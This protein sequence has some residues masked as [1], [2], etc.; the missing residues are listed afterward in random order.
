MKK[1]S[2]K[3]I[4]NTKRL[5]KDV[6]RLTPGVRFV[7]AVDKNRSHLG[8]LLNIL[9]AYDDCKIAVVGRRKRGHGVVY[10]MEV[11]EAFRA[12]IDLRAFLPNAMVSLSKKGRIHRLDVLEKWWNDDVYVSLHYCFQPLDA[13]CSYCGHTGQLVPDPQWGDGWPRCQSCKSC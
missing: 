9:T 4:E 11:V 12:E 13:T 7:Y 8:T 1:I 2:F 6:R 3:T 5:C 10:T